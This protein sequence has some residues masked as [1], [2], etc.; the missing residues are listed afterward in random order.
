MML[1]TSPPQVFIQ[2]LEGLID[3]RYK[4]E[5]FA[6]WLFT[7]ARRRVAD[8][9]RQHPTALLEDPPS[10]EPNCWRLSKKAKM[11]SDLLTCWHS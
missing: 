6:A 8:Y 2:V 4:K 7:I 10:S 3:N 1:K 9:F 11:Y 5:M